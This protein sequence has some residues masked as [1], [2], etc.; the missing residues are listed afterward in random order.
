ML[1]PA[2]F[3]SLTDDEELQQIVK[4]LYSLK[5][6]TQSALLIGPGGCGKTTLLFQYAYQAASTGK[7]VWYICFEKKISSSFPQFQSQFTVDS[8]ILEKIQMK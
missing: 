7:N 4:E 3:F 1:V 5:Y 6:N 8:K 2:F